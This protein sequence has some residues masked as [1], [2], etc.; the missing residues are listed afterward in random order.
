MNYDD[1]SHNGIHQQPT[2]AV[3]LDQ[4]IYVIAHSK[5]PK[6]WEKGVLLRQKFYSPLRGGSIFFGHFVPKQ[7]KQVLGH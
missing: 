2:T 4:L 7:C 3:L 6:K 5:S 1:S